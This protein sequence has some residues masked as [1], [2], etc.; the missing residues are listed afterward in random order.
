MAGL[1]HFI[2][3]KASVNKYEP[4]YVNQFE[5]MITPPSVIPVPAG[6]PG[7]GNILLEQVKSIQG[8]TVDMNPGEIFQ[9]YKNAKRYYAGAKPTRSTALDLNVRFEVNLDSNNS[10]YVYK[11]MRQWSDLINNPLTGAM[12]LKVDYTGTIVVNVF[13]K[14]GNVHR[15]LT[16]HNCF[17]SN[18]LSGM[19]PDYIGTNIYELSV[20][21]SADY[22]DDIFL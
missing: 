11:V 17:I 14:T 18:N 21:F 7:N 1:P 19:A 2:S 8:L 10:M 4:V 6:I 13:N 3:S 20:D 15:K 5:V 12:G 22:F 9:K 16:L